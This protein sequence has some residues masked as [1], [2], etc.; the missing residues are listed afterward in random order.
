MNDVKRRAALLE[1]FRVTQGAAFDL[2]RIDTG[3]RSGLDKAEGNA[4][5]AGARDRLPGLQARLAAEGRHAV[6]IVLQGMDAA[7][8]DGT[9]SHVMAG[10]N[11]QGIDV[12]SF[13]QPGP[14]ELAHDFL[15][16]VH[17]AAPQRG[18]IAVFNRSHYEEV[19]TCRVHPEFLDAQHLPPGPRD[20]AFWRTRLADIVAFERYLA[21]QGVL[22]L[23]FFLHVGPD[24]QR[25]RLLERL[26]DPDRNWKFSKGD[27]AERARWPDYQHAYQD[28]LRHTSVPEAPWFVVPADHKWHTRLI[29]SEAIVDA[30]ERLDLQPPHVT[31]EALADIEAARVALST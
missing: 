4:L 6:L 28:A 14:V 5:A 25:R 7:G 24:E 10:M 13:K 26:D 18:R 9:I 17:L 11:P 20:E 21:N 12:T 15:W 2:S 1:P 22:I 16:R 30:L 31:G 23:K 19:L 3:A 29:V 27:L 8:K